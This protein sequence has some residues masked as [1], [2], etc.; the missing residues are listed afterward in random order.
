MLS[1]VIPGRE[2]N[3]AQL[4]ATQHLSGST[5][6]VSPVRTCGM[7]SYIYSITLLQQHGSGILR[8]PQ[9]F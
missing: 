8:I 9:R 4:V 1:H 2:Q 6:A 7:I 5:A 3:K